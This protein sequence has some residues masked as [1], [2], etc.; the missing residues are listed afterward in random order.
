MTQKKRTVLSVL[1]ITLLLCSLAFT[2]AATDVVSVNGEGQAK[3]KVS[4]ATLY[5]SIEAEGESESAAATKAKERMTKAEKLL[6]PIGE[7]VETGYHS[8]TDPMNPTVHVGRELT[9]T[10]EHHEKVDELFEKLPE[11]GGVS[12][13]CVSYEA[14]DTTEAAK[15]ALTRAVADA[16]E[17]ASALGITEEPTAIR[18][19]ECYTTENGGKPTIVCRVELLFDKV[20]E[21]GAHAPH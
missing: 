18:E 13:Y 12:M 14:T 4:R 6:E 9:F 8:Y 19:T 1:L 20:R 7:T 11:I 5:L 3:G 17:K 16:K 15:E 21:G 10:T 2:A